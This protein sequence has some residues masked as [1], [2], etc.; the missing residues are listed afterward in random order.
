MHANIERDT[1]G[2]VQV[3]MTTLQMMPRLSRGDQE[4]DIQVISMDEVRREEELAMLQAQYDQVDG[5]TLL[6]RG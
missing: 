3:N 5:I 1:L 4:M 6:N 2:F